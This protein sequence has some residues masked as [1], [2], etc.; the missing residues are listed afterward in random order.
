MTSPNSYQQL[1]AQYFYTLCNPSKFPALKLGPARTGLLHDLNISPDQLVS[2][3]EAPQMHGLT[4]LAMAYSG[5]QFGHY[6]PLLGDGRAH[7]LMEA[8]HA[9]S[10]RTVDLHLKGSGRTPYSRGG[11]GKATLGSVLRE[12]LMSEYLHQI[13]IPSSR[14]AALILTGESIYRDVPKAGMVPGAILLRVA[15]S[16]VRV[17]TFQL[18]LPAQ[19][20]RHLLQWVMQ[21]HQYHSTTLNAV[22]DDDIICQWWSEVALKQVTLVGQWMAAGFI[23]G[24]MNT[25]N[26][27]IS[28]ETLDFGPCALL[29]YYQPHQVFSS[30]DHRGRYAF[31][32][33]LPIALWNLARLAETL[34][35]LLKDPDH[36]VKWFQDQLMQLGQVGKQ[37]Y[38][39]IVALKLGIDPTAYPDKQ[40]ELLCQQWFDFLQHNE[41][42]ID[43]HSSYQS[44][45]S[46]AATSVH[47][48][49]KTWL[50]M[51][52]SELR[53]RQHHPTFYLR[54]HLLEECI[55]KANGGEW[56]LFEQVNRAC[57]RPWLDRAKYPS[58]LLLPGSEGHLNRPTYCGT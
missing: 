58:E 2:M 47:A 30:I 8:I 39:A 45:F 35:P 19:E 38:Q 18:P 54:N 37:K 24:V 49:N 6:V 31:S 55:E 27:F 36:A 12:Y 9:P 23:H 14:A 57:E 20:R 32:Q 11:D 43:Y 56:T 21:R 25:D 4:P 46:D 26:C 40:V 1:P 29:E 17:G 41:P 28:G 44:L 22:S 10:G 5:Q 15:S 3:I 53:S 50:Q 52:P 16:H 51:N 7:L 34:M 48:F 33:Q 42:K 13:G